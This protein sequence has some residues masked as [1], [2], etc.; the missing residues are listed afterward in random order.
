MVICILL[1]SWYTQ[2]YVVQHE[3]TSR[4]LDLLLLRKRSAL[5]LDL[6]VVASWTLWPTWQAAAASAAAL[7]APAPSKVGRL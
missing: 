2:T 3:T 4:E 5:I 1:A 7:L 6:D